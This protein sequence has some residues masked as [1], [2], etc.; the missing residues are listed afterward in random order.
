MNIR[1]YS[2]SDRHACLEILESN[3]PEFFIPTDCDGYATFLDNLPG[4]YFVLEQFGEIAA[5]GG[6]AM[7]AAGVADLTWGMVRRKFHR[8]GLGRELLRFRLNA[9][10]ND[11]RA[12]LVRVR[13]AQ[14]VQGFFVREGF[15]VVDVVLNGFGTGL[16]KVTMEAVLPP[17][18][19]LQRTGAMR[20]SLRVT[21]FTTSPASVEARCQRWDIGRGI[22]P[23]AEPLCLLLSLRTP[24]KFGLST[25]KHEKGNVGR[26]N[27]ACPG[28]DRNGQR[29]RQGLALFRGATAIPH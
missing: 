10:R 15:S 14:L 18:H 27:H 2:Q 17:N 23:A 1:P 4:R 9:I 8:R 19:A 26:S 6:W 13:T 16:D 20:L 7:D 3:T 5:C 24:T 25:F 11:G 21:G 29:Q 22:V 28:F 12:T